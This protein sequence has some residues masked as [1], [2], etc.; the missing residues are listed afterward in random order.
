MPLYEY[1]CERCGPFAQSRPMAQHRSPAACPVCDGEAP[2]VILTAPAMATVSS[3][4]RHAHSVNERAAHAP[5]TSAELHE[6]FAGKK[7]HGAGCG[8]AG[9]TSTT[10]KA[11]DGSIAFP[12]KRPWMISH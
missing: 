1:L 9:K 12:S 8:G 3:E 2:R 11:A 7:S 4:I 5:K 10:V 6:A